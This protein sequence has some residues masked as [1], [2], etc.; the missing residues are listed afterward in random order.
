MPEQKAKKVHAKTPSKKTVHTK[1]KTKTKT[2]TC[3][4][5]NRPFTKTTAKS[6]EPF[7]TETFGTE[8]FVTETF[9]TEK[10]EK[11]AKI[12]FKPLTATGSFIYGGMDR[13]GSALTSHIPS[14][15][16]NKGTLM[17]DTLYEKSKPLGKLSNKAV[18]FAG[19]FLD[20]I[21]ARAA[22]G[23]KSAN[24]KTNNRKA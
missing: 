7:A 13:V 4:H 8:P 17:V 11:L 3:P 14:T 16:A 2:H 24:N 23:G 15:L 22:A 9:G 6:T 1:T 21:A 18:G 19:Y 10:L 20:P 12:A 5:C